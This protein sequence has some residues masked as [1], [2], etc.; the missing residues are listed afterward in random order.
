MSK[1]SLAL[2]SLPPETVGFLTVLGE[3]LA[4]ARLRRNQSQRE[5]AKRMGVSIPTLI[6]MEHGDQS[7]SIGVYATALWLLGLSGG[8]G[9]LASPVKDLG[10]LEISI[11]E[12]TSLRAKRKQTSQVAQMGKK[13]VAK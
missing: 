5:W 8:L 13:S 6:R 12:A 4:L 7:V 2:H 10:A 11:R 1:S 9:E 3:H